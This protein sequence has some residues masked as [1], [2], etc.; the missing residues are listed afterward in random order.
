MGINAFLDIAIGLILMYLLLALICTTINEWIASLAGLR[1]RTLRGSVERMLDDST[2]R[3]TFYDNGLIGATRA[4]SGDKHASYWSGQTFALALLGSLDPVKPVPLISDV[5]AAMQN[6]PDT[7]IRDVLLGQL[8]AADGDMRK[9]REGLAV[10][11][12]QSMDRVSGAYKRNMKWISL[13]VASALTLACNADSIVVAR[14]LWNDNA[15]R[16]EMSQAAAGFTQTPQGISN[17]DA[18]KQLQQRLDQ[19]K[20]LRPLPLGWSIEQGGVNV[21]AD[22]SFPN[23]LTRLFGWGITA[24]AVSLGAPFWFDLLTKFV[25]IRGAGLPPPRTEPVSTTPA[26]PRTA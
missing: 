18:V 8:A 2:L 12:D 5:E 19:A 20:A 22:F 4:A 23:L 25:N 16:S 26:A 3:T 1:A 17:D 10:W 9:L 24:L 11:F 21:A 15:L 14:S 13:I 7:N 6:L